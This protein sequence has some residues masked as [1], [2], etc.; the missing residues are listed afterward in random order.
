MTATGGAEQDPAA[1]A[2]EVTAL[3]VASLN[4][5]LA[6]IRSLAS[7]HVN[8]ATLEGFT[9]L[10]LAVSAGHIEAVRLLL[11][12]GA[13][14]N[15]SDTAG[16]TAL[17]H[18]SMHGNAPLVDLL[19]LHGACARMVR[20]GGQNSVSLAAQYGRPASLGALF[21]AD[22]ALVH[23]TDGLGRTVLHWA[24][25]SQHSPTVKY[26]LGRWNPDVHAADGEGNTPLHLVRG[27]EE[28]LLY[29]FHGT[30][31]KPSLTA[32]NKYGKTPSECASEA[33][34][35]A[36]ATALGITEEDRED[37]ELMYPA[38]GLEEGFYSIDPRLF[39]FMLDSPLREQP[40]NS[41]P[42]PWLN[43]TNWKHML[44]CAM[45]LIPALLLGC[46][47]QPVLA[48]ITFALI[49]GASMQ[50][51]ALMPDPASRVASP[52][53]PPF[54]ALLAGIV[55]TASLIVVF[56]LL[57][58]ATGL[59]VVPALATTAFML[60]YW[61]VWWKLAF[62]DPGCIVGALPEH[63]HRY[64]E[65][66]E[67]MAVGSKSPSG[68]CDRSE[69]FLP[70]RAAFSKLSGC[71]VRCFDHDCPWVGGAVGAG[72][73]ALFLAML[74]CGLV[75][76]ISWGFL[77][78]F[79]PCPPQFDSWIYAAISSDAHA[80]ALASVVLYG[81]LLMIIL[82]LMLAPLT[83]V[84]TYLALFNMTTREHIH[85]LRRQS[86]TDG[87]DG[88]SHKDGHSHG[89]PTMPPPM[90][91]ICCHERTVEWDEYAP[92]DRGCCNNVRLF[93][94]GQRDAPAVKDGA[95]EPS[96][97]SESDVEMATFPEM[98]TAPNARRNSL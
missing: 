91:P 18:A 25:V 76:V 74:W 43:R 53:A 65:G 86:R 87:V 37:G 35:E 11:R 98:S 49:L 45:P 61:A 52:S 41:V 19:L 14:V 70:P 26:V 97:P 56:A 5:D 78:Y 50:A 95:M 1:L 58:H 59:A 94:E 92:Y 55:L 82:F 6:V 38:L 68:F 51:M 81:V 30:R 17:M 80:V 73:H 85:W 29:V 71:A 88:H 96:S 10:S 27:R 40:K 9:A 4:G 79:S 8:A 66:F 63:A 20:D 39:S 2:A 64:W 21:R 23:E 15:A 84:H 93:V 54:A 12:D 13:D 28:I 69:L 33:G 72:N 48:L 60:S 44:T 62:A 47:L 34:D 89:Y 57:P 36:I 3:H 31:N 90:P 75:A 24:V 32:R 7:K 77:V 46:R 67:R 22:S 83:V 42:V 16:V